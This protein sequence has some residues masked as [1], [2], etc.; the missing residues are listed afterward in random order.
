MKETVKNHTGEKTSPQLAAKLKGLVERVERGVLEQKF[1]T[2]IA[3]LMEFVNAWRE[4]G[5]VLSKKHLDMFAAI[6]S[7]FAPDTAKEILQG[8]VLCNWPDV[9]DIEGIDEVEVTIA[10]QING[11]L[12]ATV[13]ISKQDSVIKERVMKIV[14]SDEKVKKWLPS[15]SSGQAKKV[16]F[17]PG[18]LVNLIV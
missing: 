5:M 3:G 18:K 15:A 12:R 1:N 13:V 16:I 10:V 8:S 11:K 4:E 17:V 7:L 9:S 6:L 14:M 2:A